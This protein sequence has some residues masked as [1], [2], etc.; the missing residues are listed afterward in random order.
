MTALLPKLPPTADVVFRKLF[1]EDDHCHLLLCL[2]NAILRRPPAQKLRSLKLV[3]SHIAGPRARDKES[4]LDLRAEAHDGSHLHIEVQ[5]NGQP[6]YPARA[7]YYWSAI[8]H[9]QL[10]AGKSYTDLQPV[11][12]VHFLC[13]SLFSDPRH[14][15]YHHVFRARADEDDAILSAHME[16]HTLELT[17]LPASLPGSEEPKWLY[18]LKHG[19][20]MTTDE[21]EELGV[22]AIAEADRKLAMISQSRA[23]RIAY[24]RR[25]IAHHDAVS[26]RRDSEAYGRKEGRKEGALEKQRESI[27]TVL[28]LRGLPISADDEQRIQTCQDLDLLAHWFSAAVITSAT[29]LIFQDAP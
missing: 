20:E 3:R 13:F 17:K 23:L 5:V 12:S 26:L 10:A 27:L 22:P 4:V 28:R 14:S 21:V 11:I 6:S 9:G 18:Y 19:H 2:L 15:A 1:N 7:L 24:E 25:K 16:L 8:Y 29:H